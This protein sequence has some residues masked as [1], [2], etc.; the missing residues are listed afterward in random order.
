MDFSSNGMGNVIL[1]LI[2]YCENYS[3][4][5]FCFFSVLS[6]GFDCVI[7]W[8]FGWQNRMSIVENF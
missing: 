3:R 2:G 8:C 5:S 4:F 6:I 7:F 1:G